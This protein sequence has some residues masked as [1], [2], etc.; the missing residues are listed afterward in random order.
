VFAG[1]GDPTTVD[2]LR[3]SGVAEMGDSRG[4]EE[5]PDLCIFPYDIL[6]DLRRVNFSVLQVFFFHKIG[7]LILF[8]KLAEI[9]LS[10][11]GLLS[12]LLWGVRRAACRRHVIL[13]VS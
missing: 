7:G 1:V 9:L 11:R 2:L 4:V 6:Q 13:Y 10:Y 8:W 5:N 12:C 3:N